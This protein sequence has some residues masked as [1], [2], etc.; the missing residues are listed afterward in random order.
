V[1]IWTDSTGTG[2]NIYALFRKSFVLDEL[3]GE[4]PLCVFADTRYGLSVNGVRLGHGPARFYV[5]R[6]EY[7]EYDIAPLLQPGE[8]VVAVTVNSYGVGSFHSEP[9]VGGLIAW[10]QAGPDVKL[11][12][13][14][15]WK[16]IVSPG[17]LTG[18]PALSFAL[19]A[20]EVC[21]LRAMPQGWD[22]P[23]FDDSEWPDAVP[24]ADQAHWGEL[25]E[26]SI[27]LLDERQIT[28]RRAL[29][30]WSAAYPT[31]EDVY[32]FALQEA[33]EGE[34]RQLGAAL[35][36]IYSPQEQDATIGAWWGRYWLNGEELDSIARPDARLRQDFALHLRQGWNAFVVSENVSGGVWEFYMAV[37][38]GLG[39]ELSAE[40]EIGSAHTFL[41]AGPWSGDERE[42]MEAALDAHSDPADLADWTPWERARSAE[43]PHV[44]S[45]WKPCIEEQAG[46]ETR[47]AETRVLLFD[48]DTEVLGRPVLE[49][50][51]AA[52]T[53][54][55]L[56]YRERLDGGA[57]STAHFVRMAERFTLCAGRQRVATFHPRGMRYLELRI[58]GDVEAF[59]LHALGL[60]RANYPVQA[61][62]AFECSDPLLNDIW[63]LGRRTLNACMEDAFLDCPHRER[64]LYVGDIFVQFFSNL[65]IYG[66]T[67]LMRRCIQIYF[68]GQ[69]EDG[70]IR[71]GAHG[72]GPGHLVDYSALLA[73]CLFAYWERT[74]DT[75]FVRQVKPQLELLM[76]ALKA[77]ASPD[78]HLVDGDEC[79]T[80]IDL[81]HMDRTGINCALNCFC[82]TAFDEAENLMFV[83][84]DEERARE[85]GEQAD[86]IAAA[87]RTAF[88][89]AE[90]AVFTDRRA[91]DVDAPEPSAP[92]NALPLLYAIA[93]EDQVQGAVQWL[94]EAM[95]D[96]FLTEPP[97]GP[98][99]NRVTTYFSYYALGALFACGA[100]REALDF[101]RTN[102]GWMLEQGAWT[103]WE[104]FAD[105]ASLCHAWGSSPMHYLSTE[106]LGVRFPEPGNP[107]VV[108]IEPCPGDLKWAA[109]TYPHPKGGIHVAWRVIGD[110]LVV[111]EASVPDG[112]EIV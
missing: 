63:Q 79:S 47:G 74:G 91:C 35:T 62:G 55:D 23:G 9:S 54:L 64:G 26:R 61:V 77:Q 103:S 89:D 80:Y 5:S 13:D 95:A 111:L 68:D 102:W 70:L 4:V 6:P 97:K 88:W 90:R 104:Y 106:V 42:R 36:Y 30:V 93:D 2:R 60:T 73:P 28:P 10:G 12:T 40:R 16:G 46:A 86:R 33:P 105:N 19:N 110:E 11:D 37:P 69:G 107:D 83:L 92:A 24:L 84:G 65:A 20:A 22:A 29:G 1:Y 67:A 101:M 21:D 38:Q 50:T 72:L 53:K 27:P 78:S 108:S 58:T 87:I 75:E 85:Y 109:G 94:A 99:D 98:K 41:L 71:S 32:S 17:H 31:G 100:V 15:G 76:N 51:A 82:W 96:N 3:P 44:E 8:N 59:E 52:G 34:G 45:C 14:Q 43:S 25:Q 81:S 57:G 48:F 18:T 112:V 56:I 66:D 7:D 49:V 39:L